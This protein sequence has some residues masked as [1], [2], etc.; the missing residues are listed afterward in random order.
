MLE[1]PTP[2][3]LPPT[4]KPPV[5]GPVYSNGKTPKAISYAPPILPVIGIVGVVIVGAILFATN[6][7]KQIAVAPAPAPTVAPS[8]TPKQMLSPFATQSAFLQFETAVGALPAII[9]G[10]AIG[11]QTLNP[12]TVDLPLGFQK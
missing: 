2:S 12:P 8:P 6:R 3:I 11:D 10:A 1:A 7:P 4:D 5:Y 9:S